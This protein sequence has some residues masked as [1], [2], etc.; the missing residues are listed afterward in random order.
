MTVRFSPAALRKAAFHGGNSGVI[1]RQPQRV[2]AQLGNRV[3]AVIAATG[4]RRGLGG[5]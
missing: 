3:T 2:P 5:F 1:E 4:G